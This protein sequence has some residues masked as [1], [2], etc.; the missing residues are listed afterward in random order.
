MQRSRQEAIDGLL[1]EQR[2]ALIL[3]RLRTHGR[4]L[5]AE[6]AAELQTSEHTVRRHLRELAEQ[7]HCK[8]VYGGA[9]L[10]S[11]ADKPAAIRMHEAVDRKARLAV[12]AVSIVRP[13]QIILLDAG[14]TNVA[15]ANALPDDADL[16]VVTNSPEAG[17][18]L[19]NRPGFD[20]IL[21]GGRIARGAAGSL[22]ATALLQIQQIRADLCF[23]GACAF[24]P[25]EG[26]AAFDAEDAELK[27]AMVKSS[28]RIAI[29][30]T[31]EKLMTA[32]PFAVAPAGAV[33]Y[34]FVEAEVPAARIASL[35]AVCDNVMVARS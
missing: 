5:A 14:S 34:L 21:V 26:V 19:L 22:G 15:I 28:G 33:D 27:R 16:T 32:A 31:S 24:D 13:K 29:A 10:I 30:L 23:L 18:R 9:L 4:V 35:K 12:A 7:G 20:V 6:L 3:E 25:D 1:P 2:E 8:R 17:A 11:P